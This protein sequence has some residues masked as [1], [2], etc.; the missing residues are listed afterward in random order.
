[1][2]GQAHFHFHTFALVVTRSVTLAPLSL[3]S[4]GLYNLELALVPAPVA[5][6]LHPHPRLHS[7]TYTGKTGP[8]PACCC[9]LLH[10]AVSRYRC[11]WGNYDSAALEREGGIGWWRG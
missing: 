4:A 5:A 1:M 11:A 9:T 10:P 2:S 6:H 3:N 8:G 7:S